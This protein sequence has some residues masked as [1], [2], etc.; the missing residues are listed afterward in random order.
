VGVAALVIM[1]DIPSA[2][3]ATKII[4]IIISTY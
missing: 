4:I 3:L 1:G 2:I